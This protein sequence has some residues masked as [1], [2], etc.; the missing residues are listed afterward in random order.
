MV[1]GKRYFVRPALA[2]DGGGAASA[3][4]VEGVAWDPD[5]L[6]PPPSQGGHFA[7]RERERAAAAGATLQQTGGLRPIP[8]EHLSAGGLPAA[9]GSLYDRPAFEAQLAE[10]FMPVDLDTPGLRIL[11]FDPPIF[12]LP[13]FFS[14]EQCDDAV[15][16][17]AEGNALVPSKVGGGNLRDELYSAASQRRTSS[18][19]LL[20]AAVQGAHPRLRRMAA[21]LQAKGL[22]LLGQGDGAAWGPPGK[23]PAPGQYCYESLQMARYEAGQHFLAHEDGFPAS[24][25]RQNGFQRHATLLVYLNTVAQ[26]GATRFDLLNLAVQPEKGKALLFF[27][28]FADG[29]ADPRTLHT[30]EDAEDTKWVTQQWAARG[31]AGAAFDPIAAALSGSM[32]LG[33][34]GAAQHAPQA[35]QQAAR[36]RPPA[37]DGPSAAELALR[38][39]KR[40]KGKKA[41]SKG[42]QGGGGKGFGA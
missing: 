38:A 16:A 27:P 29:T 10:H 26:G 31:L 33:G 41:G 22:Q 30:A 6:L 14:E 35:Q 32:P 2:N 8:A 7:R 19:V 24:L 9:D 20:D 40:G 17:A 5:G 34:A 12:T 15:A 18:S 13:G 1:A 28:A 36:R 3:V 23:L 11:H 4:P 21:A 25:A 39:A 37:E 42:K